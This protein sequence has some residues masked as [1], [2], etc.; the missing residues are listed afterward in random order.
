MGP[1]NRRIRACV[2]GVFF[3]IMVVEEASVSLDK[4]ISH[5]GSEYSSDRSSDD[6]VEGEQGSELGTAEGWEENSAD[7]VKEREF[8][9]DESCPHGK[10]KP[11]RVE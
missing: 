9:R 6:E 11:V 3:N 5:K 8:S 4:N 2:D 1:I 7:D 10:Y